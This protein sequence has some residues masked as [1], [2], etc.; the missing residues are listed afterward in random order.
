MNLKPALKLSIEV[1]NAERELRRCETV[2]E[3]QDAWFIHCD[4]FN[5]KRREYLHGV[6]DEMLRTIQTRDAMADD[7]VAY[8]R[9][10]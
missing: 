1:A 4:N 5:G 2:D 7:L 6:H 8:A 3:L 9:T 10:L